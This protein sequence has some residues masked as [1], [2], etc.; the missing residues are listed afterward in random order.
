[1]DT[2]SPL[3]YPGGKA[4]LAGL[5]GDM[6]S[7]N[8]LDGCEYFEPFAGGAGAALSLLESE[9]VSRIHLNDADIRLYSFWQ[10]AL[11]ES[12][13]FA[14]RI[15]SIPL[16]VGEWQRQKAICTSPTSHSRFDVGFAAFFMNRCNRS[17]VLTGAG[18]IGGYHQSGNWRLDVRFN[19]EGL[20]ARIQ[21]I[22]R[23]APSIRFTHLDALAFL[24]T[25]LPIGR[26]R[27]KVFVYLD[28]PYVQKG[29][30]LY[31]NAYEEPDHRRLSKYL[32][33]QRTLPW[34]AS[35]DDSPLIRTLYSD[36][37]VSELPIQYS[38]Q[39]KRMANELAL[40]PHH[41]Y[42]PAKCRATL[43]KTKKRAI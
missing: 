39:V 15:H 18:P 35:Y 31:L 4:R 42:L 25:K 5:L 41:L 30:R 16:D 3:R 28:P 32:R 14:D 37:Q 27:G 36:M 7:L 1:M 34:F 10:S 43:T 11:K 29:Q 20:A 12:D 24:K 8:D 21:Q 40:A 26:A 33:A 38:L 22:G 23:L 13:R 2:V 9:S 17:G 19:R 6:I